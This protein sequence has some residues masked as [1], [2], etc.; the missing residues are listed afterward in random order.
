MNF[1]NDLNKIIKEIKNTYNKKI[2]V[3]TGKNSYFKSG[4]DKIFNKILSKK[5]TVFF[6]KKE[7]IPKIKELQNIFFKINKFKPD[8]FVSIGGGT[9]IDYSKII[10]TL[11]NNKKLSQKIVSGN[12]KIKNRRFKLHVIPTTAGSGAEV[13]ENAVIYVNS[14]KYSLEN[15]SL[16]PFAYYLIPSLVK[17]SNLKLKS[18]S[19][20]DAIS[21]AIESILSNKANYKSIN[22]AK[23]SLKLSVRY[24][25]KFLKNNSNLNTYK[26]QQAANFSGKA[27]NISKTTAPHA[28]SYPFTSLFNIDHG[29]AVS[30]TLD[31][32]LLFNFIHID[33]SK[34][35]NLLKK[36]YQLIFKLTKSKNIFGLISF[37]KDLKL[38]GNLEDNFKKLKIDIDKNKNLILSGISEKRLKNNPISI[39]RNDVYSIIKN[40]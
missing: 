31:K 21:Q 37:I 3:L 34:N 11:T 22:Y 33:K 24:Y 19:G 38:L 6:F 28:V 40:Y 29:H 17:N 16:K 23:R 36:K 15:K 2:F 5:N 7:K 14:K 4:A 13:T 26:M 30:I 9:I 20:F 12:L 10:N 25:K 8:I 1:K 18:T 32:F 35:P 27:I 39:T